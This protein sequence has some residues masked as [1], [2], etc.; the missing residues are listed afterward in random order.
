M[1]RDILTDKKTRTCSGACGR[2]LPLAEFA[3]G[4][5]RVRYRKY[6]RPCWVPFQ[7][8]NDSGPTGRYNGL[9]QMAKRRGAVVRLTRDEH[10]AILQ[11]PCYFCEGPLSDF[12]GGLDRI[13]PDGPYEIGNV[14]PACP[15]CNELKGRTFTVEESR[16]IG[17]A[18]KKI[19]DARAAAGLPPP[20]A[21]SQRSGMGEFR[22]SAYLEV[23]K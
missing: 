23:R 8:E 9:K 1:K 19:R 15:I 18:I 11:N 20:L 21:Y 13:D 4:K 7:R 2:E 22:A 12:G 16:I 10:W 17:Q 14:L 6:C 3:V 5:T